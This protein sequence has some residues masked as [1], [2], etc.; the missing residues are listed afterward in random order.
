MSTQR[1]ISPPT[2]TIG[3]NKERD[4]SGDTPQGTK[5]KTG[6]TVDAPM[7]NVPGF[8]SATGGG[9]DLQQLMEFMK[10]DSQKRDEQHQQIVSGMSTLTK[11]L[12][13]VKTG[14]ATEAQE[15]KDETKDLRER[16]ASIEKR[17]Q[18]VIEKMVKTSLEHINADSKTDEAPRENQIIVSGWT[19]GADADKI[20]AEIEAVLTEGTRRR[21]VVKVE[22]WEDPSTF[23]VIT[24]DNPLAKFG[25]FKKVKNEDIKTC[26]GKT[27]V[28]RSNEPYEVRLRSKT[29][30]QI[31]CKLFEK[32]K[33][34]L[35][36]MKID[37][38]GKQVILDG[39]RI[40]Y[41][42]ETGNIKYE[43]IAMDVK[44]EVEAFMQQW[45]D[46]RSQ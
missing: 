5:A 14:L 43:G 29:L 26:Q 31:K 40:A 39:V 37:R 21:R 33:I 17:D 42:D 6:D 16:I 45:E 34:P 2:K 3:K 36:K 35:E 28:F 27:M 20:V 12:N 1:D 10:R 32:K 7:P 46:K 18:T 44:T 25:F 4:S 38:R 30:G 41:F 22:T 13:E 11:A 9:N 24:F 15:R 8:P 19:E 23:G